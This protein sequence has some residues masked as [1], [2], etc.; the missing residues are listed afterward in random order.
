MNNTYPCPVIGC[1]HYPRGR[2][3]KL[4]SISNII[5]HLKGDD[6]K[7]SRH[8]LDH[9]LCNEINLFRCTHSD[10]SSNSDVF[11]QSQRQLTEHN[12][13]YHPTTTPPTN[14]HHTDTIEDYTNIIFKQP[15]SEH[16]TNNWSSGIIFILNNYD[17]KQP[18][19]R[20]SWR[21]YLRGN[22]KTTFYRTM[23]YIITAIIQSTTTNES[24]AFWWLLLHYEMLILAPTHSTSTDTTET[25]QRQIIRQRL[26]NFQCGNIETLLNDTD[27]NTNWNPSSPRP[28]Q[29]NGNK[30][31]QVAADEDNYRTALTRACTFNKIATITD[32]NQQIVERLYPAK[33]DT[34][35][36]TIRPTNTN[37]LHLPGNICDTIRKAN[38]NK[39]TGF[40][41]DS[42][43][44]FIHLVKQGIPTTNANIQ[45]LFNLIYQGN[46]PQEARH[47]FTD[48][49]LFC[50]HKDESDNTKLRPIG[51]PTAIRR[52]IASHIAKQWKDKFA[53]YLLPYNFA[54][55]V[56]NGMDFIIKTMQL[57]IERFIDQPQRRNQLPTR[58]AVFVDLTN[59][60]NS[61]SRHELFDIIATD[62]PELY[63][64]TS[65][66]YDVNGTVHYKWNQTEW[67]QLEMEDGVNQGCPLSPIFAT[68]VLHRILQ[69][70]DKALKERAQARVLSGDLGDD[71]FGSI[72]HLLAYM[73]DISSTVAYDDIEF[74]CTEIERLGLSR[75]C[76]VNPQ[77]TRILTS[78]SGDSIIDLLP[79]TTATIIQRTIAKYSVDINKDKTTTPVELTTGFRLLGTPVGSKDFA[80]QFYTE[81]LDIV[82]NGIKSMTHA[83]T[84]TQTRLKLFSTC[85]I[86]KL[87]HLLDSEIMHY[88]PTDNTSHFAEWY[89]WAGVL[90][91]ELESITTMFFKGL[92]DLSPT[93]P[94]PH[95]SK[96]ICHLNINKGGLGILNPS[97]RA[98]PDYVLN[99]MI[100]KRRS[101]RG[102]KIN[103]DIQP[104]TLH[105]SL[106]TLYDT[107][108][109]T[110]SECLRIYDGLIPHIGPLCCPPTINDDEQIPM[111]ES[112][113]SLKSARDRLKAFTGK[114]TTEQIYTDT[115]NTDKHLLLLLPSILSPQTS[116]PLIGMCRSNPQHRLPNWMTK[117]ALKR[118]LRLP[119]FNDQPPICKCG[120][121]HDKY[122]DHSFKCN[123]IS[124]KQ[125]HN[126]IRDCW[127]EALQ[128]ALATAGYIRP[129][130]KIEIERRHIKTRDISAQP[131]DI[132]FDPDPSTSVTN[133]IQCP[134]TTIGADITI[135]NSRSKIPS[136]LNRSADVFTSISALADAHLQT[137]ERKKFKR[138][139]KN[140]YNDSADTILGEDVIGDL[141][142]NNM[143]LLPFALDP[144]G[145][146]G[147]A[148]HNFLFN[149][150]APPK[151]KFKENFPNASIMA[152][153]A[154]TPP[155][156][157][158][159]LHTADSIW[160][161]NQSRP[162]YGYSYTAPTPSI[163]TIQ[164]LGLGITKGLMTILRHATNI[165]K[166]TQTSEEPSPT[167]SHHQYNS[168][169]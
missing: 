162:F 52:I 49:Y 144:H 139:D 101:T 160:K 89:N 81:Q 38:K 73:D 13:I 110:T 37:T 76:I 26:I 99:M 155:C 122:G 61:V 135:G 27:F 150:S 117:L 124:K 79:P 12:A 159:I 86:Q 67:H 90:T 118:K 109:N 72:A 7:K 134:Y 140:K 161:Q 163:H 114:I 156:P 22:N 105:Q 169:T 132:C 91:S 108:Q 15:G 106:T 104:V 138:E 137:F 35:H 158:G 141:L 157:L 31:A 152:F 8:L 123:R 121:K 167:G 112:R 115:Y 6:H 57:S 45:E 83:I 68:L 93:E 28:S 92:L 120:S 98:A 23:S 102:F 66:L 18:H 164:Q 168:S 4:H 21:Q 54:V 3:P 40:F 96:L 97:L 82:R 29:R 136:S 48:T 51:I 130:S 78:C 88:Y 16:L 84:D 58:S 46:I 14:D 95:I 87:P 94:L 131:F 9:S 151:Y 17:T 65:L 143:I 149:T 33:R 1:P 5:R 24:A 44:A 63:S 36:S 43:D 165:S 116:Y 166:P 80:Y 69:P 60:F 148:L 42:I 142:H 146:L 85:I 119:I 70:L 30:A 71:G 25:N 47:F 64:F 133:N 113:I 75:G 147:P 154:T 127:A 107:T 19:F 56:P 2:G 20:S 145:R 53:L 128:P 125:G 62:F 32:D 111:F 129:S 59:M 41:S 74:F 11:F 39:G 50:L 153:K 77:K 34:L 100:C 103:D 126:I 55:G 10:C